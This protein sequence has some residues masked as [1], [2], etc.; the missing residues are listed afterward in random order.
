M[1]TTQK[2]VFLRFVL[3]Q[4]DYQKVKAGIDGIGSGI[5][6]LNGLM[7]ALGVGLSAAG[8]VAFV[9]SAANAASQQRALAESVGLSVEQF[10]ALNYAA[11]QNETTQEDLG[12][13]IFQLN[14]L[15]K[16]GAEDGSKAAAMLEKFGITSKQIREGAVG[17][18]EA[19]RIIA[20]RFNRMPEGI[21][22][23][24]LA[25]DL[26]GTKLGQRLIPFLNLGSKGF[27]EFALKGEAA[28]AILTD[29]VATAVAKANDKLSALYQTIQ[30]QVLVGLSA[31][32]GLVEANEGDAALEELTKQI[33]GLELGLRLLN[34][35]SKKAEEGGVLGALLHTDDAARIAEIRNEL[36][37]LRKERDKLKK[38]QEDRIVGAGQPKPKGTVSAPD[39]SDARKKA[40]EAERKERE[41]LLDTYDRE[42][43][44]LAKLS[45]DQQRLHELAVAGKITWEQY[46]RAIEGVGQAYSDLGAEDLEEVAGVLDEFTRQAARNMQDIVAGFL[47][48]ESAGKSFVQ[49]ILEGLA[50]L[51]AELAA[52]QLLKQL[53][54]GLA[55]SGNPFLAAIGTAFGGKKLARGGV[56]SGPG[57]P[58]EDKVPALLSSGEYVVQASAVKRWGQNFLDFINS[59]MP[60]RDAGV[61]MAYATG[62]IVGAVSH[63][64]PAAQHALTLTTN[65]DMRN[66]TPE[67]LPAIDMR[68]RESEARTVRTVLEILRR[69]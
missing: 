56:V 46:S 4:Q 39:N 8:L 58:T 60:V 50:D 67:L 59:G 57:G 11:R 66:V 53:F 52:Q 1:A 48:G 3:N 6:R 54:G 41:R 22:K 27:D 17:T 13:A 15:L 45:A 51:A 37:E 33:N 24:A 28:G 7:G 35:T 23:S 20:D 36:V 64:K 44:A 61:R 32:F 21:D 62:G 42:S 12:K 19:L 63:E 40:A 14:E 29:K 2:D 10:S 38:E 69:S 55:G 68:I 65:N 25:A 49:S 30:T 31:F 18:S 43:Q 16:A 9:K 47:R 5:Q 26:L 34:E